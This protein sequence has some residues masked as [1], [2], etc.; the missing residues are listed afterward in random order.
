MHIAVIGTGYIGLV[1]GTTFAEFGVEVTCI[2]VDES[3]IAMLNEGKIPI[4]EP[5]LEEMVQRNMKAGRLHFTTDI[6]Q[7]VQRALVVFI[8][9]GT[10]SREDGTH[11][12]DY[13]EQAARSIGE[14]M[15]GYKVIVMKSTVPV[16]T[17][18]WLKGILSEYVSEDMFD[19]ASN[20]E[21]LREG[22]AIEDS[23]RPD[24]VVIGTDSEQAR[25]I[26]RDLYR[27]LYLIETP[28]VFTNVATSELIKYASNAFLSTK[29]SFINEMANICEQIGGDVH[30]VAKAMGL[31]G[32][33]GPKFLRAGV[34]YGGSCFPKDNSALVHM[35]KELGAPARIVEAVIDVNERQMYKGFEKV[36]EAL[37]GSVEGKVIGLLGLAFKPETDDFRE[38]PSQVIVD[39]IRKEGGTVQAFDPEGMIQAKAVLGDEGITYCENAYDAIRGADVMVVVTEWN[40]FR[41]LD[42]ERVHGLLKE[43]NIVDLR[44]VY[45]PAAVRDLGFSYE[46]V[47]RKI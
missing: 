18:A 5:G 26:L 13:A 3:K 16:G 7:G 11:N 10:P 28:F 35:A 4:Y 21:F 24:R 36:K 9:V 12:M 29:I 20:P 6:K 38:A 25:A 19:I 31:D 30:V 45:E 22:S 41:L 27:P 39:N 15:N 43:P 32:R 33:I 44:N 47:G 34:G 2:D 37:G 46:C 14:A 1:T 8:G 17:G 42:L 40:E 23:V